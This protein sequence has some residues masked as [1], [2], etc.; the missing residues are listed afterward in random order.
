VSANLLGDIMPRTYKS[1]KRIPRHK[2]T[3]VATRKEAAELR[4]V[5]NRRRTKKT[6]RLTALARLDIIAPRK[7]KQLAEPETQT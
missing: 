3:T 5:I 1:E 2:P 7:E 4:T 6:D